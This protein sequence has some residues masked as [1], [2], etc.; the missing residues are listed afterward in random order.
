MVIFLKKLMDLI[1]WESIKSQPRNI[2]KVLILT[3][4]YSS[5]QKYC[6]SVVVK[7]PAS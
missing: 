5:S 4:Q 7:S 6:D 1:F 2:V 3:V